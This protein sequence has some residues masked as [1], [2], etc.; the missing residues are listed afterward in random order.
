[1]TY[2]RAAFRFALTNIRFRWKTYLIYSIASVISIP[3]R[4]TTSAITWREIF[5]SLVTGFVMTAISAPILWLGFMGI[6]RLRLKKSNL[7][8]LTYLLIL[9]FGSL[10]GL[11][12]H[13]LLPAFGLQDNFSIYQSVISSTIFTFVFFTLSSLLVELITI[14]IEAFQKEFM[15]ATFERLRLDPNSQHKVG[16][17]EYLSS[18]ELMRT[19]VGKHLPSDKNIA[20]NQKE[21]LAAAHEIQNQIQQVLRPLSHRLWIGAF[22]EIKSVKISQLC[23]DAIRAPRFSVFGL[24]VYQLIFGFYGISL[25]TNYSKA[26]VASLAG[27]GTSAIIIMLFNSLKKGKE[28]ISFSAGLA[29]ILIMATAPIVI[30]SISEQGSISLSRLISGFLIAPTLPVFIF[31]SSLYNLILNDKEFAIFAAKSVRMQ[32]VALLKNQ[33]ELIKIHNLAGYVHNSLQPELLR[34]S[35][36]LELNSESNSREDLETQLDALSVALGRS[37]DDVS[38]FR[39]IG[40]DRLQKVIEAWSGIAEITLEMSKTLELEPDKSVLLV[41]LI[42][43]MITNSIRYGKAS[44]IRISIASESNSI[45]VKLGHNGSQINIKDSGLGSQWIAQYSSEKP[46]LDDYQNRM[47]YTLNI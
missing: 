18:M 33:Q 12:I 10:R 28:R 26:A 22:G 21:I 39:D 29:F 14:P 2:E 46:Y 42:E 30:G 47:T 13:N 16:E 15:K 25:V 44:E 17:I 4:F 7:P 19:A 27:A 38:S 32:Q 5:M 23:A 8:I 9:V 40:L 11:L 24:I 45:K 35:K 36:H 3:I 34:I 41:D 43:E 31:I 6:T 1:V 37:L 20:P